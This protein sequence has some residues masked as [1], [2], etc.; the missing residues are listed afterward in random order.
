MSLV[1]PCH[2]VTSCH[3]VTPCHW[4]HCVSTG[5][6]VSLVTPCH[7][8]HKLNLHMEGPGKLVAALCLHSLHI[9]TME[10]VESK[11]LHFSIVLETERVSDGYS[12][13]VT[14]QR[15]YMTLLGAPDCFSVGG[16]CSLSTR[17]RGATLEP[18]AS[19]YPDLSQQFFSK[20]T[21]QNSK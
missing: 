21:R 5:H 4:S 6:T 16:A 19:I 2:W 10:G 13:S 3:W 17:P 9:S 1:T 15:H 11:V 18:R 8:S 7:R 12:Y 20:A 14:L